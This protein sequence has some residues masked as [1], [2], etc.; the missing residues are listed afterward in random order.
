MIGG[1]W[2]RPT[3][4]SSTSGA[5]AGGPSGNINRKWSSSGGVGTEATGELGK[6]MRNC[7]YYS[8]ATR[9]ANGSGS[10]ERSG[11]N[12]IVFRG[13]FWFNYDLAFL[14][15]SLG[16]T[17]GNFNLSLSLSVPTLVEGKLRSQM[18]IV[19]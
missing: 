13:W 14:G 5:G 1:Q 4:S 19:L 15:S 8:T 17:E 10:T 16:S 3:S 11:R 12:V 18:E 7:I 9:V 2:R 6:Q